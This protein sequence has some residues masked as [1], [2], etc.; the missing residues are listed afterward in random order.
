MRISARWSTKRI[1]P[2]TEVMC[3]LTFNDL[4]LSVNKFA[5]ETMKSVKANNNIL[6]NI[7]A[8][9]LN[10]WTC[11]L[12]SQ[13]HPCHGDK[14]RTWRV[15]C[16]T[17]WRGQGLSLLATQGG[18]DHTPWPE[19][20]SELYRPSDRRLSE[21]LVP[22]FADRGCHVISTTN[23]Y[24]RILDFLDRRRYSL[25]QVAPLLSRGWVDPVPEN[26]VVSGIEPGPLDL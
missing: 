2:T 7:I 10:A 9:T 26:L 12:L 5:L 20:E 1:Q 18:R 17:A 8:A 14:G 3:S 21:K 4:W 25:F 15:K 13:G 22:T 11:P 24:G 16:P 6:F 19:S 23:P